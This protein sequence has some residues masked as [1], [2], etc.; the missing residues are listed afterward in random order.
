[1]TLALRDNNHNALDVPPAQGQEI[2]RLLEWAQAAD[3]AYQMATKLVTTQFVPQQYRGKPDEATAAIL[4]GAEVG[5]SPMASL[6]A[7]DNIQGTPAPKAITLRAIVQGRGHEIRIDESTAEVAVVSGRRKGDSDWQTSTWDIPRAAAMG[8]TGKAQWKQ[9]PGA[10]LI[11]RATAETCRWIA[12]DAIMGMP[13]TAEEIRDQDAG[14]EI[15]RPAP[16]RVTAAEILGVT[17]ETPTAV[18]ETET[19]WLARIAAAAA[20]VDLNALKNEMVA[21]GVRDDHLVEAW[22]ARAAELVAAAEAGVDES[23]PNGGAA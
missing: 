19:D 9:Q 10:M 22:R 7:F 4:A 16:R 5:L 8:L 2:A 14:V 12:S 20:A 6:R 13:Y 18:P 17:D 11:A 1:M 21:A 3:A 23:E 15:S